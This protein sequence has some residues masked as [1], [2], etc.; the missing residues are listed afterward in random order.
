M[1]NACITLVGMSEGKRPFGRS[2]REWVVD[3]KM[4]VKESRVRDVGWIHLAHDG[5]Q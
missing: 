5:V 2:R 4:D 1:K 3:D